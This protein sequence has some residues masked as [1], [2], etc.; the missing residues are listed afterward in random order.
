MGIVLEE[1]RVTEF[2]L[3]PTYPDSSGI[4]KAAHWASQ[5]Y[6]QEMRCCPG[7]GGGQHLPKN[8]KQWHAGISM[9]VLL[10][11]VRGRSNCSNTN[12]IHLPLIIASHDLTMTR[13]R[14]ALT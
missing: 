2:S 12:H 11:R 4:E 7:K 3:S 5:H 6:H 8:N 10:Q 1:G 13:E 14:L 9:L